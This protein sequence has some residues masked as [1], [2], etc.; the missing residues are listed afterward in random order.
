MATE[1]IKVA[2][3]SKASKAARVP[4]VSKKTT[5]GPA[6]TVEATEK[7]QFHRSV[8]CN[9]SMRPKELCD[10]ALQTKVSLEV[11]FK[12]APES[13][14]DELLP[15]LGSAVASH[16]TLEMLTVKAFDI[17]DDAGTS[18][19]SAIA[20]SMSLKMLALR[21]D[22]LHEDAVLALAEVVERGDCCLEG[23][24]LGASFPE[25]DTGKALG[26]MLCKNFRLRAFVLEGDLVGDETGCAIAEAVGHGDSAL[27]E[28]AVHGDLIGDE[29]GRA[30][31]E[32][33]IK[34]R[35]LVSLKLEGPSLG[36]ATSRA[37]AE[38]LR[39]NQ[40]LLQLELTS[41]CLGEL[42]DQYLAEALATN[43]TL[44][45]LVVRSL[46]G[47]SGLAPCGCGSVARVLAESNTTLK[48][49]EANCADEQNAR[50]LAE[51]LHNNR[52]LQSLTIRGCVGDEGCQAFAT[53]LCKNRSLAALNVHCA[54]LGKASIRSIQL[55]LRQN[56]TL[57]WCTLSI[58]G[59][60]TAP[61]AAALERNRDLPCCWC[62]LALIAQKSQWPYVEAAV[63]S[64]TEYGFR[65]TVFSFLLPPR[66]S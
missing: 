11:D 44:Q 32:A 48:V 45:S 36:D 8:A 38:A 52:S 57:K 7:L 10:L 62:H 31:A 43:R 21:A 17:G 51:G 64:M 18:L 13:L 19:V 1:A 35:S 49:L 42:T 66:R 12:D 9:R 58:N 4:E 2:K 14:V 63:A 15:T 33:L 24:A 60:P 23:V 59:W 30:L 41:H 61:V 29:T 54:S 65:C 56:P 47:T 16:K 40:S 26:Q 50:M 25:E 34:N 27:R 46:R 5:I 53:M 55:A 22:Y 3:A 20:E 37:M 28:L 39:S 6:T